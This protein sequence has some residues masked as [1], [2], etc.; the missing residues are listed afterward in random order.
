VITGIYRDVGP[1]TVACVQQAAAEFMVANPCFK[2]EI[3]VAHHQNKADIG[4]AIIRKWFD[5]D[6]VDVIENVG[7]S[8]IASEQNI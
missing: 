1:T 8:S 3:L 7:N 6:G 5:Q 2:V 4:L